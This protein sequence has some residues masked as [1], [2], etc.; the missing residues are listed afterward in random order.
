[1]SGIIVDTIRCL[2]P[3]LFTW[4]RHTVNCGSR[5]ANAVAVAAEAAARTV[6]A[7]EASNRQKETERARESCYCR[8]SGLVRVIDVHVLRVVQKEHRIHIRQR[9]TMSA[10]AAAD[11]T[12]VRSVSIR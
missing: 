12:P 5:R 6:G 2:C 7:S 11:Q 8:A 4:H 1:M 3:S 10:A 9:V